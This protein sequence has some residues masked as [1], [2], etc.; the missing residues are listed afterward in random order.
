MEPVVGRGPQIVL[1]EHGAH[2]LLCDTS[3]GLY[4]GSTG[5]YIAVRRL[6]A[7]CSLMIILIICNLWI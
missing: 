3:A 7:L 4:V 1:F 6:C 2:A 5:A